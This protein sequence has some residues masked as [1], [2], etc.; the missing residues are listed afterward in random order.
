MHKYYS[1][2][3]IFFT[4]LFYFCILKILPIIGAS[5]SELH[6]SETALH[7]ACVC[8]LVA[9]YRKFYMHI[10]IILLFFLT[11]LFY[12][13]SLKILT[14]YWGE[15]GLD[16]FFFYCYS[17]LVFSKFLSIIGASL[18]EPHTSETALHDACV[19]LL[20]AIYCKFLN[21]HKYYSVLFIFFTLLFYFCILKI[22][23]IIAASLSELHTSE[24]A[25]HNAYVCLLVAIYRKF[26]MH[27]NIILLLF[28]YPVIL[29]L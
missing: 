16:G 15:P 1:V 21:V 23:P 6:T 4:L 26:Y 2:L 12:S 5:L 8:L 22:L 19:C 29:F 9:I 25:L 14:Y 7:N 10:N 20:A 11:Q 28:F 24:T 17:I 13:C 27:I 18:S 3:F